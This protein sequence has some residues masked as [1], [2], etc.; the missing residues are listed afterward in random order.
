VRKGP[1][2]N[3]S[4]PLLGYRYDVTEANEE[5]TQMKKISPFGRGMVHHWRH[6]GLPVYEGE[7][8]KK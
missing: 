8:V 2:L 3:S 7:G 4:A 6:S 5:K 1:S